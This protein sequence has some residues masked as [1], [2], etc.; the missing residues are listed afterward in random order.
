MQYRKRVVDTELHDALQI[1][2]AVVIEGMRGCG[3]TATAIQQANTVVRFE[4]DDAAI[5]LA[6]AAPQLLFATEPP[7]L[8]D[9]WQIVPSIWNHVRREVDNRGAR[10]QFILTGSTTEPDD[11]KL[12]P[13]SARF[14]RLRMH[15]M[16]LWEK[17]KSTGASSL[18]D[19][20]KDQLT[21]N[22]S[23]LTFDDLLQEILIGGLPGM[24]GLNVR[25]ARSAW[26]SYV[27]GITRRRLNVD[28]AKVRNRTKF[29]NTLRSLSR[30]VGSEISVAKIASELSASATEPIK[31][32]T[33][34]RYIET[35]REWFIIDDLP[36][37]SPHLRSSHAV[38]KT[39]KRY[40]ADPAIPASILGATPEKLQK[41]LNTL[42]FLFENL[43]LRDLRAFAQANDVILSHYRDQSGLEI[44]VILEDQRGDWGAVEIKLSDAGVDSA[45]ANLLKLKDRVDESATGSVKSLTIISGGKYS[46]TR[47]DGVHV[48]AIGTLGP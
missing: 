16:S 25:Q 37:W 38:R 2:G 13:G 20:L 36:A 33:V 27:E 32:E 1:L 47:P 31:A 24:L 21:P 30:N 6:L 11:P 45:A 14:L 46:Y 35:L 26:G 40:F 9:E 39:A 48:V 17:Q 19:L 8:I 41:D 43:V 29:A 22:R 3:K 28:G 4:T 44:D 18:G 5:D 23:P 10:G 34:E 15:P 42:G 7:L 12:H